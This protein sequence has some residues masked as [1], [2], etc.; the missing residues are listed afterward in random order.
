MNN[1]PDIIERDAIGSFVSQGRYD[2]IKMNSKVSGGSF[3]DG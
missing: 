1:N 3:A 2:Y